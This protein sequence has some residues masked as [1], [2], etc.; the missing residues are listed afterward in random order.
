LGAGAF[1]AGSLVAASVVAAGFPTSEEYRGFT[2]RSLD[3]RGALFSFAYRNGW[4]V[5][6][7]IGAHLADVRSPEP[8]EFA[9]SLESAGACWAGPRTYA[10]IQVDYGR[11]ASPS[12]A[13]VERQTRG[14]TNCC[15]WWERCYRTPEGEFSATFTIDVA[16]ARRAVTEA[17]VRRA[18]QQ[19][20][21]EREQFF[22]TLIF[23][24]PP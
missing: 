20:A 19:Y 5:D 21:E 18:K 7:D 2:S 1:G 3:A 4:H 14:D 9:R 11:C 8:S 23:S 15:I 22:T 12:T 24:R 17:E 16:H 6:G 13:A 10:T